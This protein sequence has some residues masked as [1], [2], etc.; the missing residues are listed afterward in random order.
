MFNWLKKVL[1]A[2][3]K[4]SHAI[5]AEAPCDVPPTHDDQLNGCI[6]HKKRGNEFLAKG[7]LGEAAECYRHAV[8]INPD[9]AEGFLNLGFVLKEQ[10]LYE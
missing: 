8:A 10:K 9:Y 6:A 1:P 4:A 5:A 7:M 3:E 2:P